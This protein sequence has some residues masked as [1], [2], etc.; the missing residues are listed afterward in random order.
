MS[1]WGEDDIDTPDRR[2]TVASAWWRDHADHQM[3][4]L[5][6]PDGPFAL[7]TEGNENTCTHGEPLPYVAPP[8]GMFPDVRE[9]QR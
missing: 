8:G 2:P 1:D 6:D 5:L 4:A 9:D 7:A 3:P